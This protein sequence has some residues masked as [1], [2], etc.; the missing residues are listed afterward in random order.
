MTS[1]R[2]CPEGSFAGHWAVL[3]FPRV[4]GRPATRPAPASGFRT[5]DGSV[6]AF[7]GPAAE[8]RA[9]GVSA[10]VLAAR[11]LTFF[12]QLGLRSPFSSCRLF[13]RLSDGRMP[14]EGRLAEWRVGVCVLQ[15]RFLA[16]PGCRLRRRQR[17]SLTPRISHP[18]M[19][20]YCMDAPS[21]RRQRSR[22]APHG[23]RNVQSVSG[24]A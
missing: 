5:L 2:P 13:R 17:R 1:D 20:P 16:T 6:G 7:G 24:H 21:L 12:L 18:V 23:G 8:G 9:D 14:T 15:S 11:L 3:R 19:R 10:T 22:P 4:T